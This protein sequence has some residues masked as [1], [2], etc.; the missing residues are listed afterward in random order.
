MNDWLSLPSGEMVRV[1]EIASVEDCAPDVGSYSR[2]SVL[3]LRN[4][5]IV[6]APWDV[7]YMQDQVKAIEAFIRKRD[8]G[9]EKSLEW[10]L[11][12]RVKKAYENYQQGA[13]EAGNASVSLAEWLSMVAE[14]YLALQEQNDA[15]R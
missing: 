3:A 15:K 6:I 9:L 10:H 13:W 5:R 4:G 1:S 11:S 7:T 8:G 2:R 14:D 12:K